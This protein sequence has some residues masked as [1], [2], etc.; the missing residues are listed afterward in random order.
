MTSPQPRLAPRRSLLS[1]LDPYRGLIAL[2]IVFIAGIVFSPI[3]QETGENVFLRSDVQTAL[4]RRIAEF[5]I[6][7]AGMTF[8]ILTGGIDL[9]VGSVLAFSAMTFTYFLI[10]QEWSAPLS[11]I[12]GVGIGMVCGLLNG[13]IISW[14]KLQPFVVTL[15]MMVFARGAARWISN[16]EKIQT[17]L[18][19]LPTGQ[20]DRDVPEIFRVWGGRVWSDAPVA[21]LNEIFVVTVVFV[22]IVLIG[23]LILSKS[24][25]GRRVYSIGGNEEA[26]RFSGINV[27]LNKT[28][29]Y[30][31]CGGLAGV[32]GVFNASQVGMGDP[33]SGLYLELDAIA[34]VVIGGTT[35]TGG[36]GGMLLTLLGVLIIGYI[37]TILSINNVPDP[38]RLMSKGMIIVVAVLIQQRRRD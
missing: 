6:L 34:A 1:Q 10:R 18:R 17:E 29:V 37:D 8:V 25:Y 2:V 35:L 13:A 30:I 9:S 27:A 23:H 24:G 3:N 15:A 28:I 21:F 12:M 19:M 16:S 20:F 4:F 31:I 14:L 32:A 11:V 7:A 26:A 22:V 5:G 36:R 33:S 38:W